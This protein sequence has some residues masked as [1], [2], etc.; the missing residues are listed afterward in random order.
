M[1]AVLV[2]AGCAAALLLAAAYLLAG[3]AGMLVAATVLALFAV[4][5]GWAVLAGR[6]G[7]AAAVQEN[8]PAVRSQPADFPSYRTIAYDLSS[9]GISRRH[10]DRGLRP[11][12]AR[13]LDARLAEQ[14]GL[15]AADDP[16]QARRLTGEDLWPLID[17]ARPPSDDHDA[18]GVSLGQVERLISRLEDK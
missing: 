8:H 13:L 6:D 7:Q 2:A 17:P 3:P 1:R 16:A 18:A 5:P 15:T 14:H 12:L 11:R 4:I 9:A 10:Y